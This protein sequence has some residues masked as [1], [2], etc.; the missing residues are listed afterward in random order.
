MEIKKIF[1]VGGGFM[2]SG[3][4][5]TAI[6]AGFEVILNDMNMAILEKSKAGIGKML[7]RNVEKGRMTQEAK[8]GAIGRL[9][10]CAE[11]GGAA[12]ADLVI[13]AVVENA[14]IKKSIFTSLSDI[15]REDAIMATNTSSISIAE[16]AS[17]VKNPARFLGM[18]FF[19]PV[20]LM[21][22]LE[23]VKGLGTSSATIEI[24]RGVGIQF[25]KTC[26]VS[27]DSPAFIVNHML[28]PMINEAISLLEMGIGSIEDIDVGMKCGLNH[29]MGPLELID[30]AGID[31]ELAVMEVLYRETGDPKYRPA[32]LL[33]DMVRMGWL[34]RKTGKGFYIYNE[35]GTR[36]PNP[37]LC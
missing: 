29:P 9:S 8:D 17:V 35:D 4:A 20:P 15:C 2:G 37:D 28:D 22:L 31:I 7:S 33:R 26:I 23:I 25:G 16:I 12:D 34:G 24:A 21:K 11:L 10:L 36:T 27:K 30:M 14:A 13:E 3:I 5:Q 1:V 18:H 6:T 32:T 19:S